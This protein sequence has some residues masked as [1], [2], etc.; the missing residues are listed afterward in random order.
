MSVRSTPPSV[1][2]PALAETVHLRARARLQ[3]WPI[4][5]DKCY[6]LPATVGALHDSGCFGP[7]RRSLVGRRTPRASLGAPQQH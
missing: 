4:F 6:R 7:L 5:G 1:K 2:N 3:V